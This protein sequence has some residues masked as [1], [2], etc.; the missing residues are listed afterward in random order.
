M[1]A[2]RVNAPGG[3]DRLELIE[4]ADP[5]APQA[6]EIRVRLH[7]TSL[8]YHDYRI[9]AGETG[10][11]DARIPMSDGAGIVE[12]IGNGVHGFAV[13]DAVMSVFHPT[14]QAGPPTIGDFSQTPGDGAD[15]FAR[16]VA[17]CPATWF[18]HAPA[19][20]T[21]AEAATL[22]TAGATAW[23]AVV[24]DGRLKAGDT[25]LVLGTGGVSIF[26]LQIARSMGAT[27]IATTSS[28]A[29]AERLRDFGATHVINYRKE[30]AWGR[31]VV[32]W[33]GGRGV[34][35][36]V[37][38]G[39]A[40]TLTQSIE[41]VRIGGYI[42]LIGAITGR[43]GEVPLASIVVKQLRMQGMTVASRADQS[44]MVRGLEASNIRPVIDRRF[45][46]ERL[47]E[48]FRYQTSGSHFG[49]IVVSF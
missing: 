24:N 43:S 1:K 46:L 3:L 30:A 2:I 20:W 8:N 26:A 33:T 27:V 45:P 25:V 39:G 41:A 4:L 14:W 32:D 48:A 12:A 31:A 35:Q 7:A 34:D 11:T 15:G 13:G 18:T 9:V 37:E 10:I 22:P 47:A 38:I 21:H 16:E 23:R 36:V 40:G 5:G 29:K 19:G 6:S 44:N 49:K 28:D 42:S 17:V